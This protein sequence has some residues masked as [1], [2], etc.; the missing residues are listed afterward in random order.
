[1]NLQVE[2][3]A[4]DQWQ[5]LNVKSLISPTVSVM[6]SDFTAWTGANLTTIFNSAS[7]ASG[8]TGL[9]VGTTMIPI[10]CP[11]LTACVV[12]DKS[13]FPTTAGLMYM[14]AGLSQYPLL[15]LN[16]DGSTTPIVYQPSKAQA[17]S[18]VAGNA[19][20]PG[21][22]GGNPPT[23]VPPVQPATN[24]TPAVIPQ[25][26]GAAASMLMNSSADLSATRQ[27][28]LQGGPKQ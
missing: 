20:V 7:D 4:D 28:V 22:P 26:A 23:P 25:A 3:D 16:S 10:A 11:V 15:Q 12:T 17:N 5:V 14:R 21:N 1:M 18:V 19:G 24:P 8:N 2:G 27:T 6:S 13:K 9:L